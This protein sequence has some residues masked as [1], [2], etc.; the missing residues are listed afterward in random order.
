M[1]ETMQKKDR[2][3]DFNDAHGET[4]LKRDKEIDFN[5]A[6]SETMLK[7]CLLY[8]SPSPRD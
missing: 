1:V 2:K 5:D 7:I 4:M 6:H 8:T 3:I